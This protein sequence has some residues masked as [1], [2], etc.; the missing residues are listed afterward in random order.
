MRVEVAAVNLLLD[1]LSHT[2]LKLVLTQGQEK[3]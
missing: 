2:V 3:N 1:K